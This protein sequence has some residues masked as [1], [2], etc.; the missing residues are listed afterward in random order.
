MPFYGFEP[1]IIKINAVQAFPHCCGVTSDLQCPGSFLSRNCSSCVLEMCMAMRS[2]RSLATSA[3][4][5]MLVMGT[6]D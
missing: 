4:V 3:I 2:Q 5:R 6:K 1:D